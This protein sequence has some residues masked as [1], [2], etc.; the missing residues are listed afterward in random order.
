[1]NNFIDKLSNRKALLSAIESNLDDFYV[2]CSSHPHFDLVS[3]NK[4]KWVRAKYVDW[5]NCI[6]KANLENSDLDNEINQIKISIVNKDAPNAWTLGPLTKPFNLGSKLEQFG[7][8]NVYQQ[9]GMFLLLQDLNNVMLNSNKLEVK[10]VTNLKMLHEWSNIVSVV[11]NIKIDIE[12]LKYLLHEQEARFYVGYLNGVA[13]S[14][15]LLYLSSGVAG[16]HAVSTLPKFRNK[17]FGLTISG[18][19]LKK[20]FEVGYRIGVLQAS[21]MGEGMYRQLGFKK[22]CDIFSY[23]LHE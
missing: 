1:M 22:Q 4:I 20:A 5:P 10:N 3:N 14:G 18:I 2:K 16:L 8:S 12:L 11:F 6:F 23:E 7:F 19:A 15:L 9:A 21:K 17:G 13:V